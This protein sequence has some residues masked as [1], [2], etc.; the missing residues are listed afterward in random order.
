M[1]EPRP[2]SVLF[3]CMGNIC[4]SPAAEVIF[5][6]LIEK[7]GLNERFTVDSA[8]TI[9]YH[10]GSPPDRRMAE[11]LAQRGYRVFGRARQIRSEDLERF[12]WIV[13]MDEANLREVRDL[14]TGG[15]SHH[16]IVPA[17]RFSHGFED[18]EVPDP[19]YG[20]QRGFDHVVRLLEDICSGFLDFLIK[21]GSR[22]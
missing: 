18:T 15:A 4:R 2:T 7:H 12:D 13:T 6:S 8:G 5:K 1:S 19:Y 11:T 3:V 9:G 17:T 20:G 22:T 16:K 21:S 10:E 14:D